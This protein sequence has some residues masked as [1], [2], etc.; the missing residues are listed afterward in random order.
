MTDDERAE[1][2]DLTLAAMHNIARAY[3]GSDVIPNAA[4]L[5]L[6]GNLLDRTPEET[7]DVMESFVQAQGVT[8]FARYNPERF[9]LPEPISEETVLY[10]SETS[11]EFANAITQEPRQPGAVDAAVARSS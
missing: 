6:F 9:P 3:E 10:G 11:E 1:L 2:H 8:L 7:L 5:R 4:L